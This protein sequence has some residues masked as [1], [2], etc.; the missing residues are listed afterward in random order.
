MFIN[1]W[2]TAFKTGA[3]KGSA[4]MLWS[5][6]WGTGKVIVPLVSICMVFSFFWKPHSAN[7]DLLTK[8]SMA[9]IQCRPM[10]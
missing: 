7:I 3:P 1:Q 9:C 8:G 2:D 4:V 10:G 5:W 6:G